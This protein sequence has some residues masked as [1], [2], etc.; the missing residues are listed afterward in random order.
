MQRHKSSS[1]SCFKYFAIINFASKTNAFVVVDLLLVAKPISAL[2]FFFK[3]YFAII[4]LTSKATTRVIS[5]TFV[6]KIFFFFFLFQVKPLNISS[7]FQNNSSK[8]VKCKVMLTEAYL[9]PIW[10]SM[11]ELLYKKKFIACSHITIF[12]KMLPHRCL[13]GFSICLWFYKRNMR[14]GTTK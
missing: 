11:M 10:T 14:K 5:F 7:T 1:T 6:L 2:T 9:E 13:T 8:K 3:N 12:P 4:K